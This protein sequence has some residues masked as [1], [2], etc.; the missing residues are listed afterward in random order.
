MLAKRAN[1][2]LK[3]S[4]YDL[5]I[6]TGMKSKGEVLTGQEHMILYTSTFETWLNDAKATASSKL[7]WGSD[8]ND[9]SFRW[10]SIWLAMLTNLFVKND[11]TYDIVQVI[12]MVVIGR[13]FCPGDAAVR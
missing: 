3:I 6:V 9:S 7:I 1:R 13:V 5:T 12:R 2:T 8:G 10:S 11:K 4:W